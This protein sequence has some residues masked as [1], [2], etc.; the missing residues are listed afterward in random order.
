MFEVRQSALAVLGDL[1]INCVKIIEPYLDV[2]MKSTI[3]QIDM[4]Y[5]PGVCNN[6]IWALGEIALKLQENIKPY[7][8]E[9]CQILW[10]QLESDE[11]V[12][13]VWENSACALGRLGQ[14]SPETLAPHVGQFITKW[15]TQIAPMPENGEKES[16]YIGMCNVVSQN[17]SGITDE[18]ALKG[19]IHV[20]VNYWE[21]SAQ[22]AE[23]VRQILEGYRSM[24]PNWNSF[25]CSLPEGSQ[26]RIKQVYGL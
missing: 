24:I 14:G 3:K 17:P 19:F 7:A 26:T 2:V 12:S 20:I 5:T 18:Q 15:A 16:A 21:P 25:V 23:A 13:S 4:A 6:A 1:A 9:L 22:L 8:E 10:K 11:G